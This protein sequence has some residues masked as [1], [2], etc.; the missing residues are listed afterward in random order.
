MTADWQIKTIDELKADFRSAIAM[1]PFGSRIK[2]ENFVTEGVPVLKGG[3]LHGAFID[4]SKCDYLTEEKAEELKS[5]IAVTGDIVITHRGTIGQVSIIP[6][7]SRYPRYVVSQSQLK[8]SL[9]MEMVNPLFVNYY[10]RSREGQHQ[11]LSYSSQ[12]G[13]PAIAKASTS[14]RQIEIPCPPI[15][16][17]N[18]IVSV[19]KVL[20]DKIELNRQTNQT[21]EQ[22][23]QAIFKSWFVDFEPTRAK[24]I[25]Q[26]MGADTATQELAAQAIICGAITLEQLQG[27]AE[28]SVEESAQQ[29]EQEIGR[30]HV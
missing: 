19:L 11:L 26:D 28:E 23:A 4:D 22:I 17:Q 20:D 13:V 25:A 29:R 10:L 21:L 18:Q 7:N 27:Y 12:V 9:N 3:N 6:E 30:A 5:S 8:V 15:Q 14:V 2:A 24:I 16:V 1:G